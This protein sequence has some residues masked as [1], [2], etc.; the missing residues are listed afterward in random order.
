MVS[1]DQKGAVINDGYN[2]KNPYNAYN[3]NQDS[4]AWVLIFVVSWVLKRGFQW[5][6]IHIKMG[7]SQY[8]SLMVFYILVI[9]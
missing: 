1:N 7:F 3:I 9:L 5:C 2:L 4:G 8:Y 6:M